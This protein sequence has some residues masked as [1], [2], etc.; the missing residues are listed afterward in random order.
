MNFP[1]HEKNF[2]LAV[3]ATVYSNKKNK[4][5]RF[6]IRSVSWQEHFYNS[7]DF[8]S[9]AVLIIMKARKELG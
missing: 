5:S 7:S 2:F 3:L 8:F 4:I 1:F 6:C 9:L